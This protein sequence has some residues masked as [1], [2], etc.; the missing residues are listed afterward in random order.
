MKKQFVI[1]GIV[2]I[3]VSVGLSGC[4]SQGIYVE[5]I[6]G[7][8]PNSVNITEKQMNNFPHLKE[9]ILTNTSGGD[10]PKDEFDELHSLVW[11]Y[12]TNII[13]YQNEYYEITFNVAD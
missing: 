1:I 12:D 2:A 11:S 10:I 13:R 5:K 3:L 6:S 8:H 4:Q 9:A 7:E